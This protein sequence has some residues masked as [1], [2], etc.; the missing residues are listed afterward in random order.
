M[1]NILILQT[2]RAGSKSVPNKNIAYIDNKKM[3]FEAPI[4]KVCNNNY[5]NIDICISSDC[6]TILDTMASKNNISLIERPKN[7]SGD[8]ASHHDVMIHALIEME[9]LKSK[10][11]EYVVVLLGNS[12]GVDL[13]TILESITAIKKG[14]YT[15]GMTVSKFNMFNPY[16]AFKLEEGQIQNQ[17]EV[18]SNTNDKNCMGDVYFFNGSCFICDRNVLLS[19]IG[20]DPFPWVGN[21]ILPIV[22]DEPKMEVD[23]FWQLSHV[24]RQF[25][26][27]WQNYLTREQ[28]QKIEEI[29]LISSQWS[30]Y[31]NVE[32]NIK[33]WEML[34]IDIIGFNKDKGHVNMLDYGFGPGWS[35]VVGRKISNCNIVGL[36]IDL[37]KHNLEF[38][39]FHEITNIT[40]EKWNGKT[41]PFQDNFFDIITAK[42][43]FH[44]MRNTDPKDMLDELIRIS[45]HNAVWIIGPNYQYD[46]FY[47]LMTKPD[48][49]NRYGEA[50]VEKNIRFNTFEWDLL[51]H[52]N[53][54]FQP[55]YAKE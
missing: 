29:D 46:K 23:D 28:K 31:K 10:N 4:N 9:K 44:K 26:T 12:L 7:I 37:P 50:L 49:M 32:F 22:E 21:K 39:K 11:Y 30:G 5:E 14:E 13:S 15:G 25:N 3:L 36:D 38:S 6:K 18:P 42:A 8:D 40:T 17:I 51:N 55:L 33:I 16:R 19:R 20:K 35:K 27:S 53:N 24:R 54:V 1:N 43:S 52:Q 47:K 34:F 45:R 2:A 41:M 48:Y